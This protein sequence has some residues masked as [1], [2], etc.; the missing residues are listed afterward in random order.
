MVNGGSD[1][2][3]NVGFTAGS[4]GHPSARPRAE[5]QKGCS[6][7]ILCAKSETQFQPLVAD[8]VVAGPL[9]EN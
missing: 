6:F 2:S 9:L 5:L 7:A 8:L 1:R 4:D 3:S